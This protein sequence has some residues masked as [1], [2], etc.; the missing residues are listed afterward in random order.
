[1]GSLLQR[2]PETPVLLRVLRG[3]VTR[4]LAGGMA[5]R[6]DFQEP[7]KHERSAVVEAVHP[8]LSLPVRNFALVEWSRVRDFGWP[9]KA[10]KG[11]TCEREHLAT[12]RR[13]PKSPSRRRGTQGRKFD[14][15]L[16][17]YRINRRSMER[18]LGPLVPDG[19]HCSGNRPR[20]TIPG[21]FSSLRQRCRATS[22]TETCSVQF[23]HIQFRYKI[24][25][26]L[27]WRFGTC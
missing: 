12:R 8:T 6:H 21:S 15:F 3:A 13:R 11:S 23:T 4:G 16:A 7:L 26:R 2:D 14:R 27:F 1:M 22:C 9:E 20:R 17:A 24:T 5:V 18:E 25:T 10:V 19:T